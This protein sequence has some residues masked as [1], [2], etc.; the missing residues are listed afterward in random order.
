VIDEPL[1]PLRWLAELAAVPFRWFDQFDE[2]TE[3]WDPLL[4]DDDVPAEPS[5]T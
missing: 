4:S 5:R 2:A 1:D 3:T